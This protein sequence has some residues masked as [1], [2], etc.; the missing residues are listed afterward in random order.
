MSIDPRHFD[1]TRHKWRWHYLPAEVAERLAGEAPADEL[2]CVKATDS[3][4]VYRWEELFIKVSG[5]L[6]L[7]S[8]LAPAARQEYNSYCKLAD[9]GV[10]VVKH[11][12]WGRSGHYTALITEAWQNDAADALNYWYQL[13]YSQQD[14][15]LFLRQLSDF[16]RYVVDSPL[17]HGDFH[18]GNILYSPSRGEFALVDLHNVGLGKTR[19]LRGK[20]E[21]LRILCELRSAVRPQD[22]VEMFYNIAGVSESMAGEVIRGK[23]IGD[24]ERTRHDW[25][26][27]VRQFLSGYA[28]FSG[29][30]H[31]GNSVLLVQRDKLRRN[32]FDP[33]LAAKGKYRT[34]RLAFEAALEQMLFSFYLSLLQ[35]PHIPVAALAPDGTLYYPEVPA[36]CTAP[37]DGD[38]EWINCYNEYLL[39]M[40][41][42]LKDYHQWILSPA[43]QLWLADFNSM[44]GAMPDRSVF[45]PRNVDPRRW[46]VR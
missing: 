9:C 40:G 5:S 21:M 17:Q 7:K 31:Y 10:P 38:R 22:L 42:H 11:L 26:R 29:F 2:V 30:V 25:S 3:R 32:L 13:I 34:T 8:Q 12:G 27:R 15:A 4:A 23:L 19:N 33:S 18:L 35:V 41:L 46:R 24:M 37:G 45:H 43:G 1:F 6:R 44:L 14:T 20:A 16:L 28:K 39:C 36:E